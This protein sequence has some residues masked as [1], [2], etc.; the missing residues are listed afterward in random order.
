M[1]GK[2]C[3]PSRHQSTLYLRP[4]VVDWLGGSDENARQVVIKRAPLHLL[5]AEREVLKVVQNH[6]CIR[7][8][9]NE[10]ETPPSRWYWSIWTT[11]CWTYAVEKDCKG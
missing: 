7:Q 1:I 5:S 8:M 2:R 6:S 9:I 11:T 4:A 10:V 3:E